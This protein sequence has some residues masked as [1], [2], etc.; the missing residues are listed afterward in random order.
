M[1]VT[2]RWHQIQTTTSM[3][4]CCPTDGLAKGEH[5]QVCCHLKQAQFAADNTFVL[6]GVRR[7][8]PA[9]GVCHLAAEREARESTSTFS[10]FTQDFCF[11]F[12]PITLT[13]TH[14]TTHR[15]AGWLTGGAQTSDGPASHLQLASKNLQ[16]SRT[17]STFTQAMSGRTEVAR[18][19]V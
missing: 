4:R 9:G 17:N 10:G 1:A 19:G 18:V 14:T 8:G 6:M 5:A 12:E 13:N 15:A 3:L 16:P 11:L 7:H 2:V